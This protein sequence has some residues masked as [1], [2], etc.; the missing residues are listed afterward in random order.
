MASIFLGRLDAED[1]QELMQD[2]PQMISV[3]EIIK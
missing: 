1:W 3:M 2:L